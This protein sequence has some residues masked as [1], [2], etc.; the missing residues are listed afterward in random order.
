[1]EFKDH[2]ST[3]ETQQSFLMLNIWDSRPH[4]IGRGGG[5]QNA[6]EHLLHSNEIILNF[7]YGFQSLETRAWN[8]SIEPCGFDV[9]SLKSTSE[10][11]FWN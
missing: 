3:T 1:M 5:L 2:I 4:F 8:V 6:R 7:T 10:I 9:G 11:W